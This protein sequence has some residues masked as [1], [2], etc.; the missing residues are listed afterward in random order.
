MA[1]KNRDNRITF[2]V[3]DEENESIREKASDYNLTLSDYIRLKVNNNKFQSLI[4]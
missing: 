1:R 2:K 3:T 4:K